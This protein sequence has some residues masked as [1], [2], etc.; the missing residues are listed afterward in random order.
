MTEENII[1]IMRAL[2]K[3]EGRFDAQDEKLDAIHSE[4]KATNGRVN[5]LEKINAQR[6]GSN[7]A[8]GWI[9]KF[10]AGIGAVA[11]GLAFV[12]QIFIK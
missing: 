6:N 1:T 2:G 9:W 12:S 4:V 10:F 5:T 8:L 3:M 7:I 11:G